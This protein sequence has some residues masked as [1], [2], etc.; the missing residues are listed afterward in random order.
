MTAIPSIVFQDLDASH[1][2]D[3]MDTASSPFR[4]PD[5]FDVDLDSVRDPSVIESMHD[6]MIDDTAEAADAGNDLMQDEVADGMPDDDMI[7]DINPQF[8]TE[9]TYDDYN[10]EAYVEEHQ[11]DEDEDILYED[12]DDVEPTLQQ[13][14]DIVDIA[15]AEQPQEYEGVDAEADPD[16]FKDQTIP[17]DQDN[18][19]THLEQDEEF[20]TTT[21][22]DNEVLANAR[23][24]HAEPSD[25]AAEPLAEEF[26]EE[27]HEQHQIDLETESRIYTDQPEKTAPEKPVTDA[28]N[29]EPP[30]AHD[31]SLPKDPSKSTRSIKQAVESHADAPQQHSPPTIHPVTL[32]YL[33]EEMSLFPP[34]LDDASS[35]YFLQD[36]S[37][38]LEPLD[39]LLAACRDILAG[40]LDHHDELVLDIAALGLHISE[41]SK[42][43]TQINLAQVIEAYLQLCRNDKSQELQPLYC[44]LSSR[45]SLASQYAYLLSACAEGKTFSEIAADHMDTPDPGTG[46]ADGADYEPPWED[47][48]SRNTS[49][50]ETHSSKQ[51]L[52]EHPP[53]AEEQ[54]RPHEGE[55]SSEVVAAGED[56]PPL[57]DQ[58]HDEDSNAQVPVDTEAHAETFEAATE[59]DR[60]ELGENTHLSSGGEASALQ[61]EGLEEIVDFEPETYSEIPDQ[62]QPEGHEDET[63]SSHTVEADLE[64]VETGGDL[65]EFQDF[66]ADL[67]DEFK[68]HTADVS[69]HEKTSPRPHDQFEAYDDEELLVL[70]EVENPNEEGSAVH[71]HLQAFP[72][73]DPDEHDL[74]RNDKLSPSHTA[75]SAP[76]G[77]NTIPSSGLQPPR[78]DSPP[79]T[80]IKSKHSKRKVDNDDELDLLEFDTPEPKRRRPS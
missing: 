12:E 13:E 1:L 31:M 24:P 79:I 47:E 23:S 52:S 71:E 56:V 41:D 16:E 36:P 80:P 58:P 68:E 29:E 4:Q 43:A 59:P 25:Q 44:H 74:S 57:A 20:V 10:M 51:V 37:L 45:V 67:V 33:D 61:Q 5:D 7:D 42:Y 66:G 62:Q 26:P 69:E 70:D 18:I 38:A 75:S 8:S 21:G 39:K 19:A 17:Q 9:A 22:D 53:A 27:P 40:T 78:P 48:G 63:N 2:D 14:T 72:L 32:V 35:I 64:Q 54:N 34:M 60:S 77:G 76:N 11:I 49:A 6:D 30:A 15:L 46:D 50:L 3:Q 73:F 28:E 65:D 55:A